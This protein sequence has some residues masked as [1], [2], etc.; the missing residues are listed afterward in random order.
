MRDDE[1]KAEFPF[2]KH[3]IYLLAEV[4]DIYPCITKCPNG[5]LVGGM[6]ALTVII[7]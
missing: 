3:D 6:E 5:V 1:C 7:T 2:H 4:L